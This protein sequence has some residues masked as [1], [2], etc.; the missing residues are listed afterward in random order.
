[1]GKMMPEF[2]KT[3]IG[4][5]ELVIQ[6]VARDVSTRYK[7]SKLGIAWSAI[8]PL[9][10]ISVYTLVFSQVFKARWDTLGDAEST[11]NYV[12]YFADY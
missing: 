2:L 1:M 9:I 5:R 3:F 7:G 10:M 8:N 12:I 4:T 11:V 6:L